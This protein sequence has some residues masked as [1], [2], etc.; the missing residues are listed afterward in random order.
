MM[1]EKF[2]KLIT[3]KSF[4]IPF[5]SVAVCTAV[6][7]SSAAYVHHNNEKLDKAYN[8]LTNTATVSQSIEDTATAPLSA[9]PESKT[10]NGNHNGEDKAIKYLAEYDRITAEYQKKRAKLETKISL[11]PKPVKPA[12]P[13]IPELRSKPNKRPYYINETEEEYNAYLAQYEKDLAKWEEESRQYD[14]EES[15]R[16]V[17][18]ASRKTERE[19]DEAERA[20][21]QK[22]IDNLE[23]QYQK[24]IENLKKQYGIK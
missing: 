7:G 20:K 6:V 3:N 12:K 15:K 1:K 8:E 10:N 22:Q 23:K 18:E 11:V 17:E 16:D 21:I 24:D 9:E 14:I 13:I 4:Y 5:A 2:I 19:K